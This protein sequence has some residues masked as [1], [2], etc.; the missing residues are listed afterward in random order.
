MRQVLPFVSALEVNYM[1][2][3]KRFA[4]PKSVGVP[5]DI[6][7]VKP[8]RTRLWALGNNSLSSRGAEIILHLQNALPMH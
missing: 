5:I 2:K 1:A 7:Q 6:P 4:S 8:D 3:G